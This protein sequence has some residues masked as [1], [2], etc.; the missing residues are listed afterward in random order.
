VV[1]EE[2]DGR[3]GTPVRQRMTLESPESVT[4]TR[5]TFSF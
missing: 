5:W 2:G 3:M 4:M 1:D